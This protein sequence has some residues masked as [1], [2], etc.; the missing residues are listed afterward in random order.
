MSDVNVKVSAKI[1]EET[2][3]IKVTA[4][5]LGGNS[6]WVEKTVQELKQKTTELETSKQD[7]LSFDGIY[8]EKNNKAAT[9]ETVEKARSNLEEKVN[10]ALNLAGKAEENSTNAKSIASEANENSKSAYDF[11]YDAAELSK[12]ANIASNE[13]KENAN[14]ALQNSKETIEISNQANDTANNALEIAGE[15][16][17]T[18]NQAKELVDTL[19]DIAERALSL[20]DTSF[21]LADK[22]NKNSENAIAKTEELDNKKYDKTGGEITGE[23][24]ANEKATFKKD[25]AIQGNLSV[26][27]TTTTQDTETLKVQDNVIVANSNGATLI[28]NGGFAVKTNLTN[29]YG[30]MYDPVGDGVKIGLG[31][32]DEN[33]K[34]HYNYGEEQFLATRADEIAGGNIPFWD[35]E[36]KRFDDSGLPLSNVAKNSDLQ[37]SNALI[38]ENKTAITNIDEKVTADEK[39]LSENYYTKPQTESVILDKVDTATNSI[40]I[41]LGTGELIPAIS[42][43]AINDEEGNNIPATYARKDEVSELQEQVNGIDEVTKEHDQEIDTITEEIEKAAKTLELNSTTYVLTLKDGKGNTLSTVDL[44]LEST[45]V[46]GSYDDTNKILSL[47]LVSGETVDIPVSDLVAGLASE[48]YVDEKTNKNETEIASVKN[49]VTTHTT[50]I[51]ILESSNSELKTDFD[52]LLE[53]ISDTLPEIVRVF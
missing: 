8:D 47:T 20:A 52:A 38:Q 46:G 31:Y 23:V 39:N 25:V 36:K 43:H 13:A 40:R 21:N 19:D 27:G 51:S 50:Q 10:N 41:D 37:Q 26:A 29:A 30:I 24:I 22:A 1:P 32:F 15:S 44:P 6:E 14:N 2:P 9:V 11:S 34:F 4:S 33:G 17:K 18:A 49:T 42:S 3:E 35:N 28:E 16:Q 48:S 7:K 53:A 45:V 12:K 5:I